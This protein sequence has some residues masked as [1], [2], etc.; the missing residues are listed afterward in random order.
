MRIGT[1]YRKLWSAS[2]VSTLGDGAIPLGSLLG[3]V[4]GKTLGLR[5]PYLFGGALIAVSACWPCRSSTIAR[6]RPHATAPRP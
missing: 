3:G 2:A 4:I 6:S 5:A 1:P